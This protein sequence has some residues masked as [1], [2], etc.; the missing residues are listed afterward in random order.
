MGARAQYVVVENGSWQRYYSHWGANRVAHD[1]LPGPAAATRSFRAQQGEGWLNDVSCE[2]AALVDHDRRVLLWFAF[3]GGVA[4]H[5]AHRAVLERTW[6]GWDVRF[7]YDGLGDLTDHLGLGRDL[8]RK[9]GWFEPRGPRWVGDEDGEPVTVVSVRQADGR[10]QAWGSVMEAT[11]FLGMGFVLAECLEELPPP[12]TPRPVQLPEGGLHVDLVERT[13]HY[14][15]AEVSLGVRDWPLPGWRGWS[16]DFHGGDHSHQAALL[17][18]EF[19]FPEVPLAPALRQLRD[20]FGAPPPDAPALLARAAAAPGPEGATA[21]VN[22]KALVPHDPVAPT[23]DELCVLRTVLDEL[24]AAAERDQGA[25][26][27]A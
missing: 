17:P 15:T 8:L 4:E 23:P 11:E 13:V 26:P 9:P 19:R 2:G 18:P 27:I 20:G 14:W 16:L 3:E 6:A 7:A 21:V 22:P 5:Q 12:P 1:L 10:V 24:I 25:G